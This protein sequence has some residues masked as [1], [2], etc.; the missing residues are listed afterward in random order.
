MFVDLHV[1]Y[2]S[3][4]SDF[5]ETLIFSS[6]FRKIQN[7]F[8]ENPCRGSR[9]VPC[10]WQDRWID[11]HDAFHNSAKPPKKVIKVKEM[12][13]LLALFQASSTS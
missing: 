7:K 1:K 4:L 3:F 9:V 11:G 12:Y 13:I 10:G 5:N 8:N 6:D 2:P